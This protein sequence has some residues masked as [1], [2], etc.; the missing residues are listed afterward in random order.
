MWFLRWSEEAA[1]FE[2]LL[3]RGAPRLSLHCSQKASNLVR[4]IILTDGECSK[5]EIRGCICD[6]RWLGNHLECGG[7][8]VP[9]TP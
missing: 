8:T 5:V 3:I 7:V 2:K 4:E 9:Q 1:H 6:R